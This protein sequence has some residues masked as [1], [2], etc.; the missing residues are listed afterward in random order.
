MAC[1]SGHRQAFAQ[2]EPYMSS[3]K[4]A[5]RGARI[6]GYVV[7][8]IVTAVMWYVA[9]N[10][11]N[12][13][14]PFITERFVAVLP[15]LEASLGATMIANVLYIAFDPPLFKALAQ[16]GLNVLSLYVLYILYQVFPVDLG[17]D[18]LNW[19][20]RLG[21]NAAAIAVAIGT[22]VELANTFLGKE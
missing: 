15:A 20:A 16:L 8:I 6:A 22:V 19:M 21:L 14:L 11:L 17:V 9:H 13:N 7:T 5:P 18:T 3:R 4:R 10:A 1:A 12:W 2:E